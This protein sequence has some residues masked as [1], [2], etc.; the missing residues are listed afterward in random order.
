VFALHLNRTIRLDGEV[1][2]VN[3]SPDS[4]YALINHSF[5]VS[6]RMSLV[7]VFIS[8]S[9][10]PL[11]KKGLELKLKEAS[12]FIIRIWGAQDCFCIVYV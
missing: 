3:V 11:R 10:P 4:P 9:L 12:F 2:S 1:T 8:L 6:F 7:K 5:N